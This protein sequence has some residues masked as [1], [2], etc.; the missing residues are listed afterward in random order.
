MG[1][2]SLLF[3]TIACLGNI[4][5]AADSDAHQQP[6]MSPLA[7]LSLKG[8][9]HTL[10]FSPD[11]SR[12]VSADA[13]RGKTDVKL[14]KTTDPDWPRA[15]IRV[16]PGKTTLTLWDIAKRKPIFTLEG[17]GAPFDIFGAL[18]TPDG[19][20]IV[21]S[22]WQ[23]PIEDRCTIKR[24]DLTTKRLQGPKVHP[25]LPSIPVGFT[26]D[27]LLVTLGFA[28]A[29]TNCDHVIAWDLAR[30]KQVFGIR[31][32]SPLVALTPVG[33]EVALA[34]WSGFLLGSTRD[35]L[36]EEQRGWIEVWALTS[37]KVL[38]AVKDTGAIV[39]LAYAPNG[40]L[41]AYGRPLGT[42]KVWD[43]KTRKEVATLKSHKEAASSLAWS[44]DGRWLASGYRDGTVKI[45]N[46]SA[47]RERA[48][49]KAHAPWLFQ[50]PCLLFSKDDKLLATAGPAGEHAG[51]IK[52]WDTSF[53]AE[54]PVQHK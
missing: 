39:S 50:V 53:L 4:A 15:A 20:S 44:H 41:L 51:E 29:N 45:W 19:K 9:P 10:S 31:A 13:E 21:F 46:V 2:V 52:L 12:L 8:L 7:T 26:S 40:R 24:L 1:R 33:N 37:G 28:F 6:P 3:I 11:G 23:D 18:F 27:G 25:P 42:V 35:R 54:E 17:K 48:S 49:F 47:A 34:K 32:E 14:P 38:A 22:D 30:A 16:E 5:A 43:T 36:S